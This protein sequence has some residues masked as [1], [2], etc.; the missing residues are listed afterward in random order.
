MGVFFAD[1][2]VRRLRGVDEMG[3]DGGGNGRW[4]F[5]SCCD[6]AARSSCVVVMWLRPVEMAE[7]FGVIC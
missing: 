3:L 1:R 5:T 2:S 6:A 7:W 4:G